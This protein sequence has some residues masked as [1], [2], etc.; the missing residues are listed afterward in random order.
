MPTVTSFDGGKTAFLIAPTKLILGLRESG[1]S[2]SPSIAAPGRVGIALYF[3]RPP[4]SVSS[5][6]GGIEIRGGLVAR[7]PIANGSMSATRDR[8]IRMSCIATPFLLYLARAF[9]YAMQPD[10]EAGASLGEF[11]RKPWSRSW[12]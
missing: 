7:C 1:F 2:M 12:L 10:G 3:R 9:P 11:A 4:F 6:D 8:S 5:T